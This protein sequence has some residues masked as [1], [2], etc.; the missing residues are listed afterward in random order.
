M[1]IQDGNDKLI[2]LSSGLNQTNIIN[3]LRPS[4]DA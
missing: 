3:F 4:E 1:A 2:S